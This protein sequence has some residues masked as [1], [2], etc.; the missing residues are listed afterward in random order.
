MASRGGILFD[1]GTPSGPGFVLWLNDSVPGG[2]FNGSAVTA[3]GA[4]GVSGASGAG[5][6][7]GI[8]E[9]ISAGCEVGTSDASTAG[10]R[11][12]LGADGENIGTLDGNHGHGPKEGVVEPAG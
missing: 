5:K 6:I 4:G 10:A 9:G 7:T 2:A 1:S 11:Y 12:R 3:G 8:V